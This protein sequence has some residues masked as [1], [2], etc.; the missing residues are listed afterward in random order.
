MCRYHD[1]S[2]ED[3][4]R[5]HPEIR[6]RGYLL[7]TFIRLRGISF[8]E[9]VDRI[10]SKATQIPDLESKNGLVSLLIGTAGEPPPDP[11]GHLQH[12]PR[13]V[14]ML[15][16]HW[17]DDFPLLLAEGTCMDGFVFWQRADALYVALA[18]PYCPGDKSSK[19]GMTRLLSQLYLIGWRRLE[20]YVSGIIVDMPDFPWQVPFNLTQPTSWEGVPRFLTCKSPGFTAGEYGRDGYWG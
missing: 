20:T 15:D 2:S 4:R 1:E 9:A 8:P 3:T 6:F 17:I 19:L 7:R 11:T 5:W 13:L 10:L 18:A 14:V 16:P 12:I